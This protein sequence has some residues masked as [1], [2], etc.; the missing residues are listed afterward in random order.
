MLC[1]VLWVSRG[2]LLLVMRSARPL[3]E[4]MSGAEYL[5]AALEWDALPGEDGCPFEPKAADWGGTTVD[6]WPSTI[7]RPRPAR[8][9]PR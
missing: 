9:N 4:M 2:S 6:A 1:P 7:P 3:S 8:Y 5:A